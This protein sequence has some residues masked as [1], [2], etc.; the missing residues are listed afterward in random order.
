MRRCV[1]REWVVAGCAIGLCGCPNLTGEPELCP[2]EHLYD[3]DEVS[4]SQIALVADRVVWTEEGPTEIHLQTLDGSA[5]TSSATF[6]VQ[7][8]GRGMAVDG[9]TIL[10]TATLDGGT[11]SALFS[12]DL[13]GINTMLTTF[14]GCTDPTGVAFDG[15]WWVGFASCA[16]AASVRTG[17]GATETAAYPVNN[18]R[19]LLPGFALTDDGIVGFDPP[20]TLAIPQLNPRR[21]AD[22][23]DRFYVVG[24]DAVHAVPKDGSASAELGRNMNGATDIVVGTTA[25]YIAALNDNDPMMFRVP[26]DGTDPRTDA[27]LIAE[28]LGSEMAMTSD[29]THIYWVTRGRVEQ[30]G[31]WRVEKC[32]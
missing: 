10:W 16:G 17:D 25:V 7:G 23:G 28:H 14:P 1:M 15:T 30:D 19:D 3:S 21:F 5:G 6:G 2:S 11:D 8:F 20:S 24:N 13:S 31:V 27:E 29:A 22:G 4:G 26:L 18:L 12:T 32:R 9:D